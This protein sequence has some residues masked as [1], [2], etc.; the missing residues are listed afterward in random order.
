[1]FAKRIAAPV[2]LLLGACALTLAGCSNGTTTADESPTTAASP[3]STEPTSTEPTST[4]S[5]AASP[6]G[7][8][9]TCY[10][11]VDKKVSS[12]GDV[13]VGNFFAL[14]DF[15]DQGIVTGQ[16]WS[17][18]GEDKGAFVGSVA[19]G[20]LTGTLAVEHVE[21]GTSETVAFSE[22]FSVEGGKAKL[23]G[24]KAVTEAQFHTY[25]SGTGFLFSPCM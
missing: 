7:E 17:P 1:M 13:H 18:Y 19:D 9:Q 11:L 15:A 22:K 8:P 10:F 23:A 5:P 3:T 4:V 12:D 21:G 6:T 16:W 25:V 14:A 20:K 24:Y 2:G